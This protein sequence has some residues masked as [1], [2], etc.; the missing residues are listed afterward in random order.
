MVPAY[1]SDL[2]RLVKRPIKYVVPAWGLTFLH[3]ERP[4]G[5]GGRVALALPPPALPPGGGCV[6]TSMPMGYFA[7]RRRGGRGALRH[8]LGLRCKVSTA[9]RLVDPTGEN[10]LV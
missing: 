6:Y 8:H 10:G 3:G 9:G 2:S 4:S 5:A 7:V 1:S